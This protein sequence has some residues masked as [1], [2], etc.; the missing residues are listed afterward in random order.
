MLDLD[1][2]GYVTFTV[3]GNYYLMGQNSVGSLVRPANGV[4]EWNLV[5]LLKRG[6]SVR[7]EIPKGR[8]S[9]AN[10]EEFFSFIT[11]ML[12]A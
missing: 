10:C 8:R 6:T 11:L 3:I 1:N 9:L 5:A 12:F 4:K 7:N 2:V